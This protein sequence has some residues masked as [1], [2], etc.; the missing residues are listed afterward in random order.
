[1][2]YLLLPAS[3]F[4][5]LFQNRRA[6]EN[7]FFSD[8]QWRSDLHRPSSEADRREHQHALFKAAAHD[9]KGQIRIGR[10]CSRV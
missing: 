5:R 7:R 3:T 10:S 9:L 2:T 8:H 4:E 6:F 1:M